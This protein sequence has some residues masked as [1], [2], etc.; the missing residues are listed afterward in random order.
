L[1]GTSD[2]VVGGVVTFEIPPLT[3][4]ATVACVVAFLAVADVLL[5]DPA[6]GV[7][8]VVGVARV[9]VD[10]SASNV[11]DAVSPA[12]AAVD[13]AVAALD[14][15]VVAPRELFFPLAPHPAATT[16]MTRPMTAAPVLLRW[17]RPVALRA[18]DIPD[19]SVSVCP[20][21]RSPSARRDGFHHAP[22]VRGSSD[23]SREYCIYFG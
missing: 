9:V 12:A 18:S 1:I 10:G 14:D 3:T 20:I 6:L 21:D 17:L 16:T 15:V 2:A 19:P 5:L 13:E 8:A 23:D 11:V 4:F 7:V 22:P